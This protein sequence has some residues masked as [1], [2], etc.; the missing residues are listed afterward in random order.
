MEGDKKEKGFQAIDFEKGKREF[1]VEANETTAFSSAVSLPQNVQYEQPPVSAD[2][3]EDVTLS[4]R[5][6]RL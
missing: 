4:T 6:G 1:D 3:Q 5:L 2:N